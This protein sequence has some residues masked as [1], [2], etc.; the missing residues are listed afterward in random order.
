MYKDFNY[1]KLRPLDVFCTSVHSPIGGLIRLRTAKLKGFNGLREMVRHEIANHCAIVVEMKG[2]YWLA[3]MCPDGLKINSCRKYLNNKKEDLVTVRRLWN[4]HN[5]K[6]LRLA[7]NELLIKWAHE[8]RE[9]DYDMI[10]GYL[11]LGRDNPKE[12]YC[13]ELCEVVANRFGGT[14]DNNQLRRKGGLIA[15][16]EVQYGGPC[17][18]FNVGNIYV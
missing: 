1:S 17:K 3:E 18:A 5:D 14:W 11:G 13:S 4:F 6:G 2:L 8:T 15:P 16:V 7:A 9:Y 10:K 12:Y